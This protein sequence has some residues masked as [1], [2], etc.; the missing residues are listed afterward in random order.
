VTVLV[1]IALC[2]GLAALFDSAT[3]QVLPQ[4]VARVLVA[5]GFAVALIAELTS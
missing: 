3:T 2:V 5:A 1:V 4:P